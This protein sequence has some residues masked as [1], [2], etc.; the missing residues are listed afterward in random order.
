MYVSLFFNTVN[1]GFSK[2]KINIQKAAHKKQKQ[3]K[4]FKQ[5]SR[6]II[7]A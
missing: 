5:K 7:V 2:D 1:F 4:T 3:K 6:K